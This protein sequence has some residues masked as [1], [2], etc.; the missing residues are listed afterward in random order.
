MTKKTKSVYG[1]IG[2]RAH[3]PEQMKPIPGR[4]ADMVENNAGGYTFALD[5]FGR[6]NRFLILG[7][8]SGTYYVNARALTKEN[9]Q[10][11]RACIAE[12]WQRTLHD[13]KVVSL[14]GRAKSNDPALFAL[15][16]M[17]ASDNQE[18]R[19][20]ALHSLGDVAR[21]GTH[22]FSFLTFVLQFRGWSRSLRTAVENWYHQSKTPYQVVKYRQR[23]GW[24][25]RDVLRLAHVRPTSNVENAMFQWIVKGATDRDDDLPAIIRAHIA[26]MHPDTSLGELV[27]LIEFARMP[28]EALPTDALKHPEIWQ[29]ILRAGMPMT[30]M[31]RNL[32]RMTATGAL[33]AEYAQVVI[34]AF[35][36][37]TKIRASRI[38]PFA[39]LIALRTYQRGHGLRGNLTWTPVAKI[40]ATLENAFYLAFGN[41]EP[42]GKRILHALDISGSMGW[43]IDSINMSVREAAAAMMLVS[44]RADG[45]TEFYGFSHELRQ[46]HLPDGGLSKLIDNVSN[47]PF[48]ATDA[49]LPFIYA[50][51]KRLDYDAVIVYTDNEVWDGR[52]VDTVLEEYIQQVGHPVKLVVVGM[53]AS[54][55]T[56]GDPKNPDI[57]NVSGM[58]ANVPG[59]VSDF[60]AGR[61]DI[62]FIEQEKL[63]PASDEADA[64]EGDP[65]D[66]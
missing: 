26:A 30:A 63:L 42:T 65:E 15:A 25:H 66:A 61:L 37:E 17:A 36:D 23:A 41:V 39:V 31:L 7:S 46:M 18:A 4:E 38:H 11:I 24:T 45:E 59:L 29:A 13:I 34:D 58:D 32:G 16:V 57:L 9:A 5:N 21:T 12:N 64:H 3:V 27:H 2:P 19:L 60:I 35:S 28:W 48:G 1:T 47:L 50:K 8:E 62:S 14:S 22:L 10:V 53:S 40:I 52:H 33:D 44:M 54:E 51:N 6:L 43:T 20:S 56:I 55:F 49:S